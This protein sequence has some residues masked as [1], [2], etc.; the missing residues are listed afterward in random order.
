[1]KKACKLCQKK[2]DIKKGW[3]CQSCRTHSKPSYW[4]KKAWEKC[5]EY[6]RRK[7]VGSVGIGQ[8][9]TCPRYIAWQDGDAGHFQ[10][11]RGNAV[12]F[13][14][15]GIHLQCKKCNGPGNGEQY[16][17]GLYIENRYGKE[18]VEYQQ[19]LKGQI[20]QYTAKDYKRIHDEYIEKLQTLDKVTII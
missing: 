5:S 16:K 17:Y 1:M 4:K 11:G 7:D 6:N 19:N 15:K 3:T 12:L 13:Y 20:V 14:D 9:C 8:C 18:E 10:S 2:K